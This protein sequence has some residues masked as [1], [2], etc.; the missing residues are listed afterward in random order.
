[1]NPSYTSMMCPTCQHE[2]LILM[3]GRVWSLLCRGRDVVEI[4][5]GEISEARKKMALRLEMEKEKELGEVA[6]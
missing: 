6:P 5:P 3:D 2:H 4:V 1:M